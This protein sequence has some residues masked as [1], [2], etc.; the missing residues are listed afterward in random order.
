LAIHSVGLAVAKIITPP[1]SNECWKVD[2][3]H[4]V[5]VINTGYPGTHTGEQ[6]AMLKKEIFF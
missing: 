3:A 1:G 5:A 2:G 6:L 4:K